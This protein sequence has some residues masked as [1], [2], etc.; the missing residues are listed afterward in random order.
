MDRRHFLSAATVVATI[1]SPSIVRGQQKKEIRIGRQPGLYYLP[2]LIMEKRQLL[3]KHTARLGLPGISTQWFN[4]NSGA[5]QI[6]Q[7]LSG[8]LDVINTGIGPL[9][10]LWDRTRGGAKGI[11]GTSAGPMHLVTRDLR[12]QSI[13]DFAPGD[14]IALP[15][16]KIS[17][18]AVLLQIAASQL[19]GEDKWDQLDSLTVQMGHP[20]AYI[21]L[22][23]HNHQVQSHFGAPP[24]Q[25]YEVK[26]VPGARV[27]A[28]AHDIIGDSLT[29][30]MFITTTKFSDEQ[31]LLMQAFRAAA[32]EAKGLIETETKI[33]MEIYKELTNDKIPIDD[34]LEIMKEPG[35]MDWDIYPKGTRIF[36]THL[37]K[38]GVIKKKITSFKDY[39]FPIVHDLPGS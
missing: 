25:Y 13:R 36:S 31:P 20:D 28:T 8:S 10:L 33:S 17:T 5:A 35:M 7:L 23:N 37:Y 32:E 18:Q 19:F 27:I 9:M 39:F 30:S 21:A 2:C 14:Q 38:T 12:I 3:E 29:Q 4:V 15:S 22:R 34:L 16:V 24:F 26:T 11:V 6:D 1:L